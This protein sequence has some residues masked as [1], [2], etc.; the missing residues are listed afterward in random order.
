MFHPWNEREVSQL[1]SKCLRVPQLANYWGHFFL[2][3]IS[4]AVPRKED[5]SIKNPNPEFSEVN[6][7]LHVQETN[8]NVWGGGIYTSSHYHTWFRILLFELGTN[9]IDF[10]SYQRKLTPI[11]RDIGTGVEITWTGNCFKTVISSTC[12]PKASFIFL[13]VPYFPKSTLPLPQ[14]GW[15]M[16]PKFYLPLWVTFF[17]SSHLPTWINVVFSLAN[18][19]F[20]DLIHRPSITSHKR[21]RES[22]PS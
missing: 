22:F 12:F 14:L 19:T 1:P 21:L 20:V 4:Q 10:Y 11:T 3:L 17:M 8:I 6:F 7:N 5:A 18:L 15:C 16:S 13:K 9:I 2:C